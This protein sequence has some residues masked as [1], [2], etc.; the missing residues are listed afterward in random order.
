MLIQVLITVAVAM[1]IA[2]LQLCLTQGGGFSLAQ[3]LCFLQGEPEAPP[4]PKKGFE[5]CGNSQGGTRA[6]LR[7]W[8][9]QA[10]GPPEERLGLLRE[11][12]LKRSR[13]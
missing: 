3:G 4:D 12:W 5:G 1:S 9:V 11:N 10:A 7:G 13:D 6:P 8:C 2:Q